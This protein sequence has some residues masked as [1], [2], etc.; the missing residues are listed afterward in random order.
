MRQ[1]HSVCARGA[2]IQS[3]R[4]VTGQ[5]VKVQTTADECIRLTIDIDS[6][7]AS[8]INILQ[9]KNEMVTMQILTLPDRDTDKEISIDV[10]DIT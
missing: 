3:S 8:D 9:W 7:Y 5:V 2:T 10:V 6:S 1:P 4:K